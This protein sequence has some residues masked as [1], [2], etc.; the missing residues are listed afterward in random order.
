MRPIHHCLSTRRG[1]SFSN[2]M[3]RNG[4]RQ[5]P[6]S[7]ACE[8]AGLCRGGIPRKLLSSGA[9]EKRVWRKSPYELNF[10]LPFAEL[11]V[12]Y[13]NG[14]FIAPGEAKKPTLRVKNSLFSERVVHV[15][16]KLPEGWGALPSAGV[17][18]NCIWYV[19]TGTPLTIAPGP[20]SGAFVQVL[21]EVRLAGR[22]NA[23]PVYIPFQVK[24]AVR[25][26]TDGYSLLALDEKDRHL[27]RANAALP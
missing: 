10:G 21:A 1:L 12:D 15:D 5:P 7:Q 23:V 25:H 13:G 26:E 9:I 3:S 22:F 11:S 6:V 8:G 4:I 19:S 18:F 2:K 27:A 16:F 14:P 17:S 20:V 24:G